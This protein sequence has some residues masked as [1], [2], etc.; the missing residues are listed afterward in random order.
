MHTGDIWNAGT[1]ANVYLTVYGERGDTGVRQLLRKDDLKKFQKGQVDL[2]NI[3]A[4]SLGKPKRLIIGH[5]ANV[6]GIIMMNKFELC[7]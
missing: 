6:L 1:D 7:Y 3:E 2:F 5:D 4:V